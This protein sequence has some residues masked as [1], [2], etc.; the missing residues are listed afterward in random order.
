MSFAGDSL[1]SYLLRPV[2]TVQSVGPALEHRLASRD[3]CCLGDLLLHLPKSYVDDRITIDI[4]ELREGLEARTRARVMDVEGSGTGK[5]RQVLVHLVDDHDDRLILRFFHSAFLL[6]DVRLNPGRW[7][8]IRGM[9][10][11]RGGVWQ[12]IH[13]QW[14]PDELHQMGW[15]TEYSTLAGPETAAS[16]P[17]YESAQWGNETGL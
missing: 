15:R 16:A 2:S 4:N 3:I 6:R 1:Y 14:V 11:R 13:P 7:L 12:M 10:E 17:A 5:R 9:P 8:S